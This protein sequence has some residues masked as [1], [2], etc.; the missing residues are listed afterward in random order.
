MSHTFLLIDLADFSQS[1]EFGDGI[2]IVEPVLPG[3]TH[4]A[5]ASPVVFLESTVRAYAEFNV[6]FSG[7]GPRDV[8]P[9]F[10]PI[11]LYSSSLEPS[12]GSIS[13]GHWTSLGQR[14]SP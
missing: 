10:D 9:L 12:P 6:A 7:G 13:F 3:F 5:P 4:P 1:T 14:A 8:F 2:R 11:V